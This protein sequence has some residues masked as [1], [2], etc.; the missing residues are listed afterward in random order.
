M[1]TVLTIIGTIGMILAGFFGSV[2]S[3]DRTADRM[4]YCQAAPAT[5][6]DD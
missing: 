5:S 2:Q 4:H 3:C 1:G 6:P